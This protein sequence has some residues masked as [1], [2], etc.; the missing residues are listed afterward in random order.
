MIVPA[1][2]SKELM[3]EIAKDYPIVV[4]KALYLSD[5][6]RREAIKSKNKYVQRFFEYKTKQLNDWIIMVDYH[7][8]EPTF[9]VVI[10][11]VD[12][13]GLNGIMVGA[14]HHSLTHYTPHF[15]ERYN[16]R[17]L[18]QE[19]MPK[20]ELLK[21]FISKNSVGFINSVPDSDGMKERL[22]ARFREGIALGEYENIL[23]V[24]NR[25]QHLKTFISNDMIFE[26]Q[27][28]DF[29]L[30]GMGYKAYWDEMFKYTRIGAFD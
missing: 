12:K 5:S 14:D 19:T 2:N 30:T 28:E 11:Y 20:L 7:V 26:S 25:I 17:F 29:D 4:N 24:G 8:K 10:Y 27:E 1:M 6:L 9:V 22:F 16:E 13:F 3:M 23:D 18:K 21:R 15:L